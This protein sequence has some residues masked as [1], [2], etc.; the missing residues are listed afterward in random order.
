MYQAVSTKT[1]STIPCEKW[2]TWI[3]VE[4]LYNENVLYVDR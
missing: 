2:V 3:P 4:V 1:E